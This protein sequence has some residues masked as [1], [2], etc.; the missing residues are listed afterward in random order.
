MLLTVLRRWSRCYS[1]SVWLDGLYY[2][3]FM[4]RVFPCSL[5]SRFFILFSI[6]ITSL[7]EEGAVLHASRAFVCLLCSSK[8]LSLFSSPWSQ[9]LTAVCDC[10][11][12]WTFLLSFMQSCEQ[13]TNHSAS[14][15]VSQTQQ[16]TNI[17]E[18]NLITPIN[19]NTVAVSLNIK[20]TN[21]LLDTGASI[22][23]FK[24]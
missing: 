15:N 18:V 9:W 24:N 6:V 2:G 14:N 3:R 23:K 1:Y 16:Q 21:G 7:G 8:L 12:P 13:T 20:I 10:G 19:R 5:S 17:G 4:F 22:I 11:T